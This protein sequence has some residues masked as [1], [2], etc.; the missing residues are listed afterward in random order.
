MKMKAKVERIG[1]LDVGSNTIK[2]FDYTV[3]AGQISVRAHR[4]Y[5]TQLLKYVKDNVLSEEGLNAAISDISALVAFLESSGCKTI[6]SF[7]T[8]ALRS[9][10]N[11][12]AVRF[13]IL[14]QTGIDVS[15]LT[16]RQEARCDYESLKSVAA[17]RLFWGVDI[18]G[19]SFQAVSRGEKGVYYESFPIGALRLSERFMDGCVPSAS[20]EKSMVSYVAKAIS[21]APL[22][23]TGSVYA[24]GGSAFAIGCIMGRG[25][26]S[27][28]DLNAWLG[29]LRGL[30]ADAFNYLNENAYGRERTL[31]AGLIILRTVAERLDAQQI[32]IV[33]NGVR[34][35]YLLLR[36]NGQL[37]EK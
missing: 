6:Y 28:G 11:A 37:I 18:G 31:A 22:E 23:K 8:E 19:G 14:A 12:E 5:H 1:L 2:A 36:S 9:C 34:E 15:V 16:G 10:K 35:G 32:S 27:V 17:S 24:M 25:A 4:T 7:A 30:G 13:E 26:V 21:K 33:Q 3:G 29:H 20:Q